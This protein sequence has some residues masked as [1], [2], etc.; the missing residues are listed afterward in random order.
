MKLKSRLFVFGILYSLNSFSQT[1]GTLPDG[2]IQ[3]TPEKMQWIDGSASL[4]RGTKICVMYGDIKKEGPFAIR[5]KLPPGQTIKP[6]TH[7]NDEVVTVLE[8]SVMIGLGEQT[9]TAQTKSFP[10]KSFYVNPAGL[11][12]FVVAG[13]E[14][15]TVQV[16]SLGP[17]TIKFD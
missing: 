12:H 1:T 4:P 17:W 8:G 11:K 9:A 6:H 15:A 13:S 2:V 16:N 14:G 5:L 7:T 3:L 10:P